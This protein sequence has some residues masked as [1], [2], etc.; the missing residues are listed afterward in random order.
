MS[1]HELFVIDRK[2]QLGEKE[3]GR[4]ASMRGKLTIAN[5]LGLKA[6]AKSIKTDIATVERGCLITTPPMTDSELVI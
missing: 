4:V 2:P 1:Q 6:Q 5:S 3:A